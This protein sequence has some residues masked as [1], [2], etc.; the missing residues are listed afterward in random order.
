MNGGTGPPGRDCC[1]MTTATIF[2]IKRYAIH[3][4]PGIRTTLFFS[5]CP[6]ECWWCHNPECH[7]DGLRQGTDGLRQVTVPETMTE[8]RKD[9]I[10]YEE[11]GGGVT[12]SGGEP[13][14]QPEFVLDLLEACRSEEIATAVDTCGHVQPEELERVCDL[15]DMVLY[16]LKLI[17]DEAHTKYT[18]VSNQLILDNL[19]RLSDWGHKVRIRIPLIPGITDTADNIRGTVEFLSRLKNV[20]L[21][22]LLPYNLFGEDKLRRHN[23]IDR[24]G[25]LKPQSEAEIDLIRDRFESSGQK[26]KVGG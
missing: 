23:M 5:G 8:I 18:G 10:F 14:A 19:V 15:T 17:D 13:L 11:S 16:D 9:L 7:L 25:H 3:D 4:G 12:L 20:D 21:I 22:S 6:L 1:S 26:V 24:L 2:N